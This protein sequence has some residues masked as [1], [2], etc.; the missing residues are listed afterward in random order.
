M[1]D[2]K[3]DN[4]REDLLSILKK[5][6]SE[7]AAVYFGQMLI[8]LAVVAWHEA[9]HG[10]HKSATGYAI[11][12]G[13]ALGALSVTSLVTTIPIVEFRRNL[14]VLLPNLRERFEKKARDEGRREG[15][16]EGRV[17]GRTEGRY[18]GRIE[19]RAEVYAKIAAWNARREA[20]QRR[21]EPFD[22]PPPRAEDDDSAS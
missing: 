16:T 7:Y 1:S 12:V 17:E 13:A 8:W 9:A 21:G 4:S 6:R 15:R 5:H 3:D 10:E 20:A 14:M 2:G 11:A 22:E 19:G 18:E